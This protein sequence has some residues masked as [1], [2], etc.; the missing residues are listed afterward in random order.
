MHEPVNMHKRTKITNINLYRPYYKPGQKMA[1][2]SQY[3]RY[4]NESGLT[5]VTF[6]HVCTWEGF[7]FRMAN[8]DG[9]RL[10]QGFWQLADP[11]IWIASTVPMLVG[12]GLAFGMR[13]SINAFWLIVSAVGIYLVE[14][15][16]NAINEY[17]DY[18]SGVDRFVKPQNRTPFSGGKKTIVQGKLTLQ[19]VK[20]IAIGTFAAAA[21]IG[22]FIMVY[23]EPRVFWVGVLGFFLSIFY[24]LPPF[25]F[26]YRGLGE[27]MV[28]I[29]FGPLITLGMFMVLTNTV[30]IMVA[31]TAIPIG[32]LIANVLWINQY[33]DYE[34]DAKGGKRNWVVR[35]GKKRAVKVYA[36]LFAV[37]YIS[38]V[39]LAV[40]YHNPVWLLGLISMPIA[41]KAVKTAGKYY[42]DIPRLVSA[43]AGTVQVYAIT[44][45]CMAI[46]AVS[47][48]FIG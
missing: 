21:I 14:I 5:A 41:V 35:L 10:W 16:K 18:E 29:T 32:A 23:R 36:L 47:N 43:N 24:S 19:E 9:E 33:P 44:G 39:I 2:G 7:G 12:S 8:K 22:L 46:A 28:G 45:L 4:S 6:M 13:G 15:G 42:D 3:G 48:G 11:K 1:G 25:M 20:A 34:A 30:D 31:V 37:A 40:L 38:F 27:L 26:A 17:I